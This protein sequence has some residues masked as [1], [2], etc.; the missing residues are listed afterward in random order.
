M[1]VI[2]FT[3]GGTGG[4]IYPGLAIAERLRERLECR[5]VWIG[6]DSGMDR[7]I[8]ETAGLEFIG[9]PSGKLRRYL[10]FRNAIDLFKVVGGFFASRKAL[11][12][13][14]P[15]LLFSKGGFVSVPP[16]AAASTLGIPVFTHESDFSM[17]LA[18]RLN[19]RWAERLF[20]AYADT[21]DKLGAAEKARAFVIG[22]PVRSSFLRADAGRGRRFLAVEAEDRVLL[23]LGGSQ[24]AREVNDLVA[25][26]LPR[27]RQ[28]FVVVHQC[29]AGREPQS[30]ADGRYKPFPYLREELPDVLAA[31]DLVVGRSGAGTVWEAATAGKAMVLVPLRGSVTRGDQEE[32]AE[33]FR[34][35]GAAVVLKAEESNGE[36]FADAILALAHDGLRLSAM[37]AASRMAGLAD[38]AELAASAII[39]RVQGGNA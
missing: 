11:K 1:I 21:R 32:N 25:A 24:G 4:H 19:L 37:S 36:A 35:A 12:K 8:V 39:E 18:T 22:N 38:A 31:A 9:V 5:I 20:V 27:L 3:G 15:R 26:A 6:S 10:S 30:A 2:A 14:Q 28:E 13:L 29:G 16:C 33:Y 34:K 7:S 17:G 23:V